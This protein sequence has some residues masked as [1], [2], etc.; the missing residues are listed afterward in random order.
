[1]SGGASTSR[2]ERTAERIE[3]ASVGPKRKEGNEQESVALPVLVTVL[4]VLGGSA[5]FG[6]PSLLGPTGVVATPNALVAPTGQMQAVLTYQR[7]EGFNQQL[8]AEDM[9]DHFTITQY[10]DRE[11]T[12]SL[13]GLEAL[14]GVA[15]GAELWAAYSKDNSDASLKT[16]SAGVKYQFPNCSKDVNVAIGASY[17]KSTGASDF[18]RVDSVYYDPLAI[19]AQ[20]LLR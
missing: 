17:R 11:E 2:Q 8:R 19:W 5:G 1:M 7:L 13:W 14:A 20:R 10:L 18:A 3:A 16:W 12:N 15:E 6:M 4:V 9:Y